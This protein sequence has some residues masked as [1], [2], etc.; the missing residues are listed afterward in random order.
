M[1]PVP[2]LLAVKNPEND[3]F[4]V[5]IVESSDESSYCTG[6]QYTY[7][8]RQ[9]RFGSYDRFVDG[10]RSSASSGFR[11]RESAGA[12]SSS[13]SDLAAAAA[14]GP[15]ASVTATAPSIIA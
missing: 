2:L 7:S 11:M 9:A 14:P 3:P 10:L 13:D 15:A 1:A 6:F 5:D 4:G 8:R 12:E